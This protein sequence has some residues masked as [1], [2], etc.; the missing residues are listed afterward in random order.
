MRIADRP[1]QETTVATHRIGLVA[2]TLNWIRVVLR[3]S[4]ARIGKVNGQRRMELIERLELGGKRQ[5]LLV[6]CD[7]Q[8]Y[9]VG[10][11]GDSVHSITRMRSQPG[12]SQPSE[13]EMSCNS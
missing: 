13:Q 2:A 4:L 7:G 1:L 3:S 9:L 10:T 11:G 5:L 8:R 6:V 12:R